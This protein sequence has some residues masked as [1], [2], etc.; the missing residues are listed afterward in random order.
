[1]PAAAASFAI[2]LPETGALAP[3][4]YAVNVRLRP[5]SGSDLALTDTVR[6]T[7]PDRA[8]P[9][10]E[11]VI[12]RRGPSTGPQHLRTADPRFQRNERLRLEFATAA[13][14]TATA[15]VLDRAGK[16]IQMPVQVSSRT[17]TASGIRWIVADATLA[18]LAP[19]DYAIELKLGDVTQVTGF[20]LVP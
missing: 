11:A 17:D 2:Q 7:V 14:G 9:V 10:G 20:R 12:W 16:A 13:E 6:V 5:E 18:P 3:G 8:A 4:D 1:V 19:G 15:R